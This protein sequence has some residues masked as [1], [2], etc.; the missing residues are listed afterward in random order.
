MNDD[1]RKL[2]EAVPTN[3]RQSALEPHVNIIR[4]LRQR[5]CTYREIARFLST[6]FN[7]SIHWTTIHAFVKARSHRS[8]RP[9][10]QLPPAPEPARNPV[11]T[12]AGTVG[13][14]DRAAVY[15]RMEALKQRARTP[16]TT[17][18]KPKFHYDGEPLRLIDSTDRK[19]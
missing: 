14:H 5:R 13:D 18:A 4:E 1:L 7:L 11:P 16:Q 8:T 6:Q 3:Q 19:D 9:V 12:K 2:V 17:D 10:Y 15:A